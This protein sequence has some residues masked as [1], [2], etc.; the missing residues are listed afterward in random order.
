LEDIGNSQ[1]V[2]K[3]L[4]PGYKM[5]R[6]F[7]LGVVMMMAI[8]YPKSSLA[9]YGKGNYTFTLEG[10]E[11][12]LSKAIYNVHLH[13]K[14][15]NLY[16]NSS[17]DLAL[18]LKDKKFELTNTWLSIY[19]K[20]SNLELFNLSLGISQ[21]VG[22]NLNLFGAKFETIKKSKTK[23]TKAMFFAGKSST[24]P[25]VGTKIN[26]DYGSNTTHSLF[27]FNR[28]N[29]QILGVNFSK[30]IYKFSL[31]QGECYLENNKWGLLLKDSINYKNNT[32][33]TEY[34]ILDNLRTFRLA[35]IYKSKKLN[36]EMEYLTSNQN[37]FWRLKNDFKS[38]GFSSGGFISKRKTKSESSSLS[39]QT[40]SYSGYAGYNWKYAEKIVP[41]IFYTHYYNDISVFSSKNTADKI[42]FSLSYFDIASQLSITTYIGAEMSKEQRLTSK[43]KE[44]TFDRGLS[45][46]Y[47]YHEFR[48]WVNFKFSKEEEKESSYQQESSSISYGIS[49][50][51][52]RNLAL[53]YSC[54]QTGNQSASSEKKTANKHVSLDYRFPKIPL[55]LNTKLSW[56]NR[57]KPTS[58]ISIAYKKRD[59][60]DILTKYQDEEIKYT[61]ERPIKFGTRTTN[62]ISFTKEF[63]SQEN[64]FHLGRISIRV[65]KDEDFD[66]HFTKKKDI[67][68]KEIK[69]K[70][71]KVEIVTN[72]EGKASFIDLPPATYTFSL[73][74]SQIPIGL[75]C[76][77]NLEQTFQIKEGENIY[78]NFPFA[79]GGKISGGVFIDKNRNG[80]WD[81]E[82]K[83]AE[84][85]LLLANDIPKYTSLTGKY[86][87]KNISPGIVK[88]KIELNSLP[89]NFE[90]TTKDTLEIKLLPKQEIKNINF[91]IA[92]IEPEIEFEE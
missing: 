15:E 47:V 28:G 49:K 56:I 80:L 71:G 74:T 17:A 40:F 2:E 63:P 41:A 5:Q 34:S 1:K 10:V 35:N 20:L 81:E 50:N 21:L 92:E 3:K 55:T 88:V 52:T 46:R 33:L 53:S 59:K 65:F 84:D 45:L 4:L 38:E 85:I 70:L 12:N 58:F 90:L 23:T 89:E 26:T 83:G 7:F 72:E 76:Q 24:S 61:R 16:F 79:Y 14:E 18:N 66:G 75:A 60:K 8:L 44:L 69:V 82:E 11:K 37:T 68:L 27:L 86:D 87:F 13:G 51:I 39:Q 19:N 62:M 30:P 64:L 67:P 25:V 42:S 57:D 43:K 36:T 31:L 6:I 91:G 48:P 9:M 73:D 22:S 77:T 32:L 29:N 78:V 54:Y